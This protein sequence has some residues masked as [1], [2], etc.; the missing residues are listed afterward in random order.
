MPGGALKAS[1]S[2]IPAFGELETANEEA[3]NHPQAARRTSDFGAN[4]DAG[5]S[6]V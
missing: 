6:G 2:F 1:S 5:V 3:A 4:I